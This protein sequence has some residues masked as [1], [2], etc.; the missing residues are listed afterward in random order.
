MK[1]KRVKTKG[2]A[3]VHPTISIADL[4]LRTEG[5]IGG[6]LI[7]HRLYD[8]TANMNRMIMAIIADIS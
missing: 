1:N 8:Q 6:A 3:S 5:V 4:N 7:F 2:T